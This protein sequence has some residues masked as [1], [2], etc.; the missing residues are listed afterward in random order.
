MSKNFYIIH[1]YKF[2][3]E[4]KNSPGYTVCHAKNIIKKLREENITERK[5][6]PVIA[7]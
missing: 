4:K 7:I 6:I 2:L 3:L 5:T 1:F